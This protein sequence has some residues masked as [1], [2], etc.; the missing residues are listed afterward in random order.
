MITRA[1][2]NNSP[3]TLQTTSHKKKMSVNKSPV[4]SYVLRP[5]VVGAAGYLFTYAFIGNDGA[6][7]TPLG[8]LSPA[9][10]IGSSVAI[11]SSLG[12]VVQGQLQERMPDALADV[13]SMVISPAITAGAA[14]LTTRVMV[15][16]TADYSGLMKIAGLGAASQVAGTYVSDAVMPAL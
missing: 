7:A 8:E 3:T 14:V 15:G 16:P 1:L 11:A 4:E 9:M 12:S 6:V 10:A 13:S 5:L 2:Y